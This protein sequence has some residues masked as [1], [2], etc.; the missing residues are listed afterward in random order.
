MNDIYINQFESFPEELIQFVINNSVLLQNYIN[1]RT[2][3]NDVEIR[4][5]LESH[6]LWSDYMLM[7]AFHEFWDI[8]S[9]YYFVGYHVTRIL[10]Y[11]EILLSGLLMLEY[12]SYLN[13]LT[14]VLS[15]NNIS[16]GEIN[17]A[18]RHITRMYSGA[19]GER[20]ERV[21]FFAP[22]TLLHSGNFDYLAR[23]Y[24]GEIAE[25]SFENREGMENVWNVLT[26]IGTPVMIKF[27]FKLDD[28]YDFQH[29]NIFVKVI[30][31]LSAKIFMDY[32]FTAELG[33]HIKK[34][35]P[36]TDIL[37]IREIQIK[38]YS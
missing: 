11:D 28:L 6:H 27:R 36:F 2:P 38:E 29:E 16:D 8:A 13:R 32:D 26:H 9:K 21:C 7:K 5:A 19:L 18:K 4:C 22:D 1:E 12:E 10:S 34:S 30:Q 35:I 15:E 33:Q 20:K 23:N 37:D 31:F 3:K 25:R 17:E 14:K 24:G